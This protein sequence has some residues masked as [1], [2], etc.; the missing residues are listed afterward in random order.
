VDNLVLGEKVDSP[1]SM[2]LPL[3]LAIALLADSNGRIDLGCP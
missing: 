2:N 1:D 3:D